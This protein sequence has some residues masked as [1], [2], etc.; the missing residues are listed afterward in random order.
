LVF[1]FN[2]EIK[3]SAELKARTKVF[4]LDVVCL[5]AELPI[6]P[7]IGQVR[8]QL[9][10]SAT[11]VAANYRSACR[12]KSKADFIAKLGIVEEEADESAFWLEF[13][14]DLQ[15]RLNLRFEEG[16]LAELD[17]LQ[18]EACQLLAITITSRKTAR[19]NS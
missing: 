17:R 8:G 13:I 19:A 14:K 18:D 1:V 9:Q 15:V 3:M 2:K 4:A 16:V 6:T 12:G 11:S 5:C 7:E 10:R